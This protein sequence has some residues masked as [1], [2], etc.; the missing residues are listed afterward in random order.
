[1]SDLDSLLVELESSI[2]R[3]VTTS[4]V[5]VTKETRCEDTFTRQDPRSQLT[6]VTGNR[7]G[8]A[9]TALTNNINELDVLLK[10]LSAARYSGHV[11][12][13]ETITESRSYSSY[14]GDR[15]APNP[16]ERS[17]KTS[18]TSSGKF[19]LNNGDHHHDV[20]AGERRDNR[21]LSSERG[22]SKWEYMG[23]GIWENKDSEDG[24]DSPPLVR[25]WSAEKSVQN[26]DIQQSQNSFNSTQRW[27]SVTTEET[28]GIHQ[29]YNSK[30]VKEEVNNRASTSAQELDHLMMSL[31]S[32]KMDGGN[33][34]LPVIGG[35]PNLEV[36]E[37]HENMNKQVVRN[38]PKMV[39]DHMITISNPRICAMCRQ[40]ITGRCITAMFRKFHPECFVCS[41]CLKQLNK[42]TFKEQGDKPYC[43]QCFDR[44]FG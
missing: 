21:S 37:L 20:H 11:E 39:T 25:R 32:F 2:E 15:V 7:Q 33:V 35:V 22:E 27:T 31:K 10:D 12:Q 29:D 18:L 42:G 9:T 44:L 4:T 30:K 13:H 16:P 3:R 43:H 41:F 24:S 36:G 1:M 23:Y 5:T 38:E 17:I 14:T 34:D 28:N 19:T 40:Q 26:N 8:M 6:K